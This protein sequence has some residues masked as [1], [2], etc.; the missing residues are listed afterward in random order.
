MRLLI[1]ILAGL[2]FYYFARTGIEY[3]YFEGQK[4]AISGDV[5]VIVGHDSVYYWKKSPWKDGSQ[6]FYGEFYDGR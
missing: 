6:P 3:A 2:L 4:D 1:S 5:R